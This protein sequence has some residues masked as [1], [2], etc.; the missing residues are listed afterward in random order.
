MDDYYFY[1]NHGIC[2]KCRVRNAVKGKT[3]CPECQ[4]K[5]SAMA[6][7]Y[8]REHREQQRERQKQYNKIRYQRLKDAGIC[9]LC[10]KNPAEPGRVR[11]TECADRYARKPKQEKSRCVYVG[12]T[13]AD[14]QM[15][16]Q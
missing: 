13:A 5:E 7:A 4:K 3:K 10:G 12:Q 16:A 8:Y 2:V 9:T 6:L 14:S 15:S 11:C 1:K